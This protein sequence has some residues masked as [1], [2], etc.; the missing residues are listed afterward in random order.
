MCE[1]VFDRAV[2]PARKRRANAGADPGGVDVAAGV[3]EVVAQVGIGRSWHIDP[4]E[5]CQLIRC[6]LAERT[7][8]DGCGGDIALHANFDVSRAFG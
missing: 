1:G 7:N 2:N 4:K 3:H 5:R 8:R 6:V